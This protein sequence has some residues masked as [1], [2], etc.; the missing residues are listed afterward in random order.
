MTN[1]E[2]NKS[3][4][5][6][7]A[8]TQFELEIISK[9]NKQRKYIKNNSFSSFNFKINNN[10]NNTHHK[11][12][13]NAKE[14]TIDSNANANEDKILNINKTKTENLLSNYNSNNNSIISQKIKEII[15]NSIAKDD[16]NKYI[17]EDNNNFNSNISN[18]LYFKNYIHGAGCENT[19]KSELKSSFLNYSRNP[20]ASDNKKNNSNKINI[21]NET[22][23]EYDKFKANYDKI[24]S[25]T[26]LHKSSSN[27]DHILFSKNNNFY[28]KNNNNEE[29]DNFYK[30]K[31]FIEINNYKKN[32]YNKIPHHTKNERNKEGI[33]ADFSNGGKSCINTI[34]LTD[35]SSSFYS[36]NSSNKSNN[37]KFKKKINT[38]VLPANP[39]DSV[40]EARE[41]FFFND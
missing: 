9:E 34:G 4:C 7:N 12:N 5:R 29:D 3:F 37:Y 8:Q 40:N 2:N 16:Y 18:N 6:N 19:L 23:F 26:R 15:N 1:N 17:P 20:I 41:Y 25:K 27:I 36:L 14:N 24:N 31:K 38:S 33:W 10:N 32:I 22:L 13:N 39:F 11:N 21:N 28:T 30:K 35:Q